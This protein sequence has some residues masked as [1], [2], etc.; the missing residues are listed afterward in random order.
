[1]ILMEFLGAM[2]TFQ[3]KPSTVTREQIEQSDLRVVK[4]DPIQILDLLKL[5]Q[6]TENTSEK[7]L[8]CLE[9]WKSTM[10]M[11]NQKDEKEVEVDEERRLLG[12]KHL[13]HSTCIGECCSFKVYG[14]QTDSVSLSLCNARP[15]AHQQQ[16]LVSNLPPAGRLCAWRTQTQR[17]SCRAPYCC[18]RC[19]CGY[20][21]NSTYYSRPSHPLL[22]SLTHALTCIQ[23]IIS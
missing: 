10:T 2:A 9:D 12:C 4:G 13:F 21:S 5:G 20:L 3:H 14:H 17:A 18:C 8:I 23:F 16:Q 6:V 7:C 1:M 11:P 19:C 22:A 15:M